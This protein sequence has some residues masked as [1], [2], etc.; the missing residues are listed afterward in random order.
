MSHICNQAEKFDQIQH[1][2]DIIQADRELQD[3][4]RAKRLITRTQT[5][6]EITTQLNNINNQ[7]KSLLELNTEY[8]DFKSFWKIGKRVGIGLAAFIT[9][10]GIIAG[11]WIAFK[12]AINH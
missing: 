3:V 5:D 1:S 11:G 6:L 9:F 8:T 2:I 7:L 10:I 4:E 12:N